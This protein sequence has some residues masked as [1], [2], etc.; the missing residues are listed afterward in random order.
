MGSCEGVNPAIALGM[1]SVF[2]WFASISEQDRLIALNGFLERCP[3]T[4]LH[5]IESL[6]ITKLRRDIISDL[7]DE[8]G[9]R[10]LSYLDFHSLLQASLVSRS[11]RRISVDDRLWRIL[12]QSVGWKL[13]SREEAE[14]SAMVESGYVVRHVG[15]A[16]RSL[17]GGMTVL[18]VGCW[19]G[20]YMRR[21]AIER[22]W[23]R[24][25]YTVNTLVGHTD[26]ISCLQFEDDLLVTGS[27]DRTVRVWDA[28]MGRCAL[29]LLGHSHVV[30]CVQFDRS[31][32]FISSGSWDGTV[33][34][35]RIPTGE[36]FA[37]LRDNNAPVLSL[38]IAGNYIITGS[39]DGFVRFFD[40]RTGQCS[41]AT[42]AHSRPVI[43]IECSG[44]RI[45]TGS[46]DAVIKV[47]EKRSFRNLGVLIGHTAAVTCI[48]MDHDAREAVGGEIISGS[49]DK[50][51][52]VWSMKALT[53][54]RI[55]EGHMGAVHALFADASKIVSGSGNETIKIWDRHRGECLHTLEEHSGCV[56][57]VRF[58][59][60]R[61]ASGAGDNTVKILDFAASDR[62]SRRSSRPASSSLT[63]RV[64]DV[65]WMEWGGDLDDEGFGQS[66][67]PPDGFFQRRRAR[68]ISANFALEV[69]AV[70]PSTSGMES[71][72]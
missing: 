20:L 6:L 29:T 46:E 63:Q 36:C 68:K 28:V 27:D 47:W 56:R 48:Y 72:T 61:I 55:L 3:P 1:H 39:F 58:D 30:T 50:T 16:H 5:Q 35:W 57:A 44:D 66:S 51:I 10:I 64:E 4:Q 23:L 43:C 62:R 18:P 21:L 26:S 7:P 25:E 9:V 8:V 37:T 22:N 49:C 59:G 53:C 42:A 41:R 34:L 15:G 12:W 32:S 38:R 67:P 40:V 31:R 17:V 69:R 65:D 33:R 13:N 60:E 24:G 19:K 70:P 2:E 11:W 71:C 14:I 45:A 52:R 54:I